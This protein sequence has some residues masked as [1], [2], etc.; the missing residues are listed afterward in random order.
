MGVEQKTKEAQE[1]RVD[2][3]KLYD[4]IKALQNRITALEKAS[5]QERDARIITADR[6]NTLEQWKLDRD[7]D[8]RKWWRRTIDAINDSLDEVR[9]KVGL[10]TSGKVPGVP[11]N[12]NDRDREGSRVD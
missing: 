6:L 9:Q 4:T 12:A 11:V 3:K 5:T 8:D 7:T 10:P 2:R 1:Q